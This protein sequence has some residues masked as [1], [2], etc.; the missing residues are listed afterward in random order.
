MVLEMAMESLFAV[1]EVLYVAQLGAAATVG[2]TESP[3]TLIHAGA[4]GLSM[5]TTAM[6][7]AAPAQSFPP[8]GAE[9]GKISETIKEQPCFVPAAR[10]NMSRG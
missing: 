9:S 8:N 6:G 7:R 5:S 1:V 3:L 10:L 2:L 4:P